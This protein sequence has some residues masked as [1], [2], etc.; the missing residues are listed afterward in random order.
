MIG[1]NDYHRALTDAEIAAGDH[2]QFVGGLWEEIGELQCGFLIAQG[3]RPDHALVDIGCGAVRGGVHFVRYL[4]PGR[5]HGLDIDSSLI[6][7]G[8]IELRRANLA[9]RDARLLLDD[10]FNLSRFGVTFDYGIAVSV[11]THLFLNH[12]ARCFREMRK[13]MH[14]DGRFFCTFFEAPSAAHVES[15]LHTPGR[16]L[17]HYDAD[18]FHY[19]FPELE[20][21]AAKCGLRAELVGPWDHPRDQ[22]MICFTRA[23]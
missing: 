22:R 2:R 9:D 17:T 4:Q 8:Q 21:L 1:V 7:A 11:F 12:I 18:P 23:S 10:Q 5:Y 13:V 16:A 3:L 19:A 15:I 14:K 20:W 6:A